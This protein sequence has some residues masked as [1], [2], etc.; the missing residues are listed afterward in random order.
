MELSDLRIFRMVV[1]AGGVTRAAERLH[2]VQSNVTTRI[3]RLEQELDV[4]LFVRDGKRLQLSPAGRVLLEY[5][6]QMLALAD[7]ARDALHDGRPRGLLRIGAMESTAAVRLP[8]PLSEFHERYPDVLMELDTGAP[9][10][11][12]ARVLVGD[13]DAALVAE[14]VSDSRLETLA[15][16]KEELAIVTSLRHPPI[17]SP[18]DVRPRTALAF[19]PGCPHRKRLEDWF[20]REGVP[21]ERTVEVASYHAI[22]GCA[23]IGMGVALMPRSVLETY[24]ERARL[25][26]HPLH[27]EFRSARTLLVWRR[28]APQVKVACLAELLLAHAASDIARS[29]A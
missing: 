5:A 21:I 17:A 22:L 11:L 25:S 27:E 9:Q 6:E 28:Q 16:Y 19:H 7:C 2:R 26:I 3:K 12:I 18:Q 4:E 1:H 20:A 8:A 24:A 29:A 23:V 15:I 14:P 13:L 10:D